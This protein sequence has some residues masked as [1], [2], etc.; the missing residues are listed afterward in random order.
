MN[1]NL[2]YDTTSEEYR[3]F[4]LNYARERM[5]SKN[6]YDADFA[7]QVSQS[8]YPDDPVSYNLQAM[9]AYR[10]GLYEHGLYFV[11]KALELDPGM[12]KAQENLVTIERA[13]FTEEVKQS[14]TE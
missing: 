3:R 7:L 10:L 9:L 5:A 2:K 11:K 6:Y 13:F 8:R 14:I 12:Q 1:Q 4:L